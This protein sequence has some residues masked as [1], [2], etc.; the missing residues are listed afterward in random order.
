[1]IFAVFRRHSCCFHGPHRLT[2]GAGL[3]RLPMK[4]LTIQQQLMLLSGVL[5]A[6]LIASGLV[7]IQMVRNADD[8][9][10][11]LYEDRVVPLKQLKAISDAY[12]VDIVDS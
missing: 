5:L 2:L 4:N 6:F 9:I 11:S 1:M 8:D 3:L 12:A 10:R 7:G